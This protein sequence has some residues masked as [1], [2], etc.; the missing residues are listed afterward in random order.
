[1]ASPPQNRIATAQALAHGH[2][3]RP[4]LNPAVLRAQE[5]VRKW[6]KQQGKIQLGKG[7]TER[8]ASKKLGDVYVKLMVIERAELR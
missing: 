8:G 4:S 5:K 6:A 7:F 2:F 3:A 1:M